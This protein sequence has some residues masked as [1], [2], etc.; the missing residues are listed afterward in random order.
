M[1]ITIL[2]INITLKNIII[3]IIFYYFFN[4]KKTKIKKNQ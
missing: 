4:K 1:K 3:I 2:Y